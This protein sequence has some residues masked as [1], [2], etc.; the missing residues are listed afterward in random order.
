MFLFNI[1]FN[2]LGSFSINLSSPDHDLS[3]WG[4]TKELTIKELCLAI[5]T[6]RIKFTFS[7]LLNQNVT[8]KA[9]N[10][11]ITG[12]VTWYTIEG[13][14]YL[15]GINICKNHR[16]AWKNFLAQKWRVSLQTEVRH[17]SP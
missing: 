1:N 17:V 4:N 2:D 10:M 6:T 14:Y 8:V 3:L 7:Q 9:D 12:N 13:D 11:I 15:I 5:P 16:A